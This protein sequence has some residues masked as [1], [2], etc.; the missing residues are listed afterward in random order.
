MS[1]SIEMDCVGYLG[2]PLCAMSR[3]QFLEQAARWAAGQES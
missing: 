1:E 3:T 2:N